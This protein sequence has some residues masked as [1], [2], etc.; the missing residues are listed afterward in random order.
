MTPYFNTPERIASLK[1]AAK[2]WEGTPFMANAAVPKAGV[3][4]QK[5]TGSILIATGHLPA[6]F[7]IPDEPMSWGHAH[8]DSI[9]EKFM[10]ENPDKFAPAAMPAYLTA[11]PGDVVGIHFGGCIH[12]CGLVLDANGK[13]IHCVRSRASG[14]QYSSL[15]EA[16]FMRMVKRVWRPITNP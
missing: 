7:Q 5:L 2:A 14:V 12:H 9:L 4:C 10:A 6:G 1:V 8:M 13:F 16:V 3:S 11:Q 15:K